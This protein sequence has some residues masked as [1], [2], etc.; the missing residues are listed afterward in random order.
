MVKKKVEPKKGRSHGRPEKL[1]PSSMVLDTGLERPSLLSTN[2]VPSRVS[3]R[4]SV[5]LEM[6]TD[7]KIPKNRSK[8]SFILFFSNS[9]AFLSFSAAVNDLTQ[10]GAL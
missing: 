5:G 3:Q 7:E 10:T 6:R 1:S 9:A 8:T 4:C 2:Q